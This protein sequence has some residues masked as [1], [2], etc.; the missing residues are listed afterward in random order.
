MQMQI[1]ETLVAETTELLREMERHVS[2]EL[3]SQ[4]DTSYTKRP[5]AE[6]DI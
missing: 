1:I 5:D 3:W 4:H 2:I 6:Q